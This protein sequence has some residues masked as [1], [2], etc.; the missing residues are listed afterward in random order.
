[1]AA[2]RTLSH[3]QAARFYDRLGAGLDTQAIY[4][5]AALRDLVAHLELATCR[6]V[7]EFGCGTGRLAAELLDRRLSPD[8]TY[9]A[10]DASATMAGLTQHRIRSFKGRAEV[11]KTDG[12][13]V[14]DAPTGAFDRFISTYVLD[15]LADEDIRSLL[16]EAHRVLKPGG[17]LGLVSLT[18]GPT[19]L[20]GL[21]SATWRGLHHLSPWLVG[22]CRPIALRAFLSD[23][24]WHLEYANVI[25][26]FGIPSEVVVARAISQPR[27][28]TS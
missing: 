26:T 13:P 7:V 1:M 19:P 20:S 15:L 17:L 23:P 4:E 3:S 10:L 22:G 27:P 6:S 16:A 8:A 9:L 12:S 11:K 5:A 24:R 21:V 14:M 2:T 25:V 18:N 28:P